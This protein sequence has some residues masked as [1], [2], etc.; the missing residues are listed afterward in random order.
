M[1][2]SDARAPVRAQRPAGGRVRPAPAA[3]GIEPGEEAARR[4]EAWLL[5]HGSRRTLFAPRG[6]VEAVEETG[7]GRSEYTYDRRGDLVGIVEANGRRTAFE[8]DESRRLTRVVHPDGGSTDYEYEDGRLL[9]IDDRGVARRF[10]Y[11]AEGR[12]SRIG[13]GGAGAS[14]YRYDDLGRLVEARTSVVSTTQ[15]Y[16]PDGRT[17]A[18]RQSYGGAAIELRME[19]DEA[20]RLADLWLPGCRTPVRYE[21]DE[22][23]RLRAV[24]LGDEPLARFEPPDESGRSLLRFRNGV[25]EERSVDPVDRRPVLRRIMKHSE[26]LLEVRSSYDPPGRMVEDGCRAYE[27]D[28]LDRLVGVLETGTGRR[29]RYR[30]DEQD[31]RIESDEPGGGYAYHHDADN[32]LT[33]VE[34]ADGGT[35]RISYDAFGRPARKSGPTGRWAY[36][37]DDAGQLLEARH[38]GEKVARFTYDHKGRLAAAESAV[39]SERY[40]YGPDDQLVAVTDRRGAPLRLYVWTPQGLLLAEILGNI[41]GG[42]I[43]FH[44]QDRQGTCRLLTDESGEVASRWEY[45]PFGT[46]SGPELPV[47]PMFGGRLWYPEVGMY[48]FGARWYDPRLGRFLTPDTFTGRPDDERLVHPCRPADAQGTARSQILG[49]WLKQPRVRNRYAFC[50]NDPV[51][52]VDPSGHWSFG[53]TLLYALGAIWTLPNTLFALFLEI[54]CLVGEVLRWLVWLFTLGHVSWQTPGFDVAGSGRLNAFALVFSGGWFPSVLKTQGTMAI[55]FGNAFF[56]DKHWKQD[57]FF[58]Q[59]GDVYPPVYNNSVAI[60]REQAL[61]EHELRH[62]NQ[63]AWF[64]PFFLVGLPVFGIYVWDWILSDFDYDK[65]WVERNAREHAGF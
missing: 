21:W 29:W 63:Y 40:L 44:H 4:V 34:A 51:G 22:L 49:D 6:R 3:S 43:M 13:H 28:E 5:H 65:M 8:Y 61:Y 25:V 52:R 59:S 45:D 7:G 30:Y 55:T 39:R 19:Y 56:V 26:T 33:N 57:Q 14:V 46:P 18:I 11:D 10:E 62:T 27:Y 41:D 60:P 38:R 64:G 17:A 16:H 31:N 20:G 47:P 42:A 35:L 53:W 23:G 2:R 54:T 48:H 37:Y 36:R 9:G 1:S 32:R 15:R 24:A 58:Q 50:G 12:I